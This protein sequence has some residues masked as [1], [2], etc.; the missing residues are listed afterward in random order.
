M[1]RKEIKLSQYEDKFDY[2]RV[3]DRSKMI[4]LEPLHEYTID[5]FNRSPFI[6]FNDVLFCDSDIKG[7]VLVIGY[8]YWDLDSDLKQI[9]LFFWDNKELFY[10][11]FGINVRLCSGVSML[12]FGSIRPDNMEEEYG[13]IQPL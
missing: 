9:N 3:T 7:K 5:E 8:S 11:I 12:G 4:L 13:K 1:L 2:H 10:R 6:I